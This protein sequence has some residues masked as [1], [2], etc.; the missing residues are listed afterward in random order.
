MIDE[1]E[2]CLCDIDVE[3]ICVECEEDVDGCR[4]E[5]TFGYLPAMKCLNCDAIIIEEHD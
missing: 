4:C 3:E 2:R 5:E 1:D